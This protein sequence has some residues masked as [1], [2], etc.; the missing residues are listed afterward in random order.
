MQRICGVMAALCVV[1]ACSN[2]PGPVQPTRLPA[3]D[4]S[5]STAGLSAP[6]GA[7]R[8]L[9]MLDQCDPDSFNAAIGP[10]TCI[11]RNGGI[12][13][14]LFISLLQEQRRVPS[15]RFVPDTIHVPAA[16]TL[17]ILNRGGEV[18]TFTAVAAF[19]G[20]LVPVLNTLSGTPVPAPE[21]LSLGPGDFVAAGARTAATFAAGEADKYQCCIHPWMRAVTR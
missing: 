1:T 4:A 13:F 2:G 18:H 14:D 17:D 10:D 11:N 19:G 12:T 16:L 21:C 5:S 3:A 15:W 20:G 9:L 8:E 7:A 6:A